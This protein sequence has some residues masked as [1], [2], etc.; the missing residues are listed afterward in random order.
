VGISVGSTES[1]LIVVE[2]EEPLPISLLV[3]LHYV[4]PTAEVSSDCESVNSDKATLQ[5]WVTEANLGHA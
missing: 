3:C 4:S 2:F 5:S 1:R